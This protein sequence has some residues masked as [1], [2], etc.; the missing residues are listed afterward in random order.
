MRGFFLTFLY[1]FAFVPVYGSVAKVERSQHNDTL[2]D[3]S[4]IIVRIGQKVNVGGRINDTI[5]V[6]FESFGFPIGGFSLKVAALGPL[7]DIVTVLPGQLSDSCKWEYF[8]ARPSKIPMP[9]GPTTMSSVWQV[10][11]LSKMSPDT[12]RVPCLSLDDEHTICY[13]VV[14]NEHVLQMPDTVVPIVFIWQD[15]RDNTIAGASGTQ[16][17]VSKTVV[18]PFSISRDS[19]SELF[20]SLTGTPDQCITYSR[21]NYPRRRIQFVNGGV[22]TIQEGIDESK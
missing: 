5:P 9:A 3:T 13:I 8:N 19:T 10:T 4:H 18:N 6:T 16:I 21:E 1:T 20:P 22:K 17:F 7:L 11:A 12:S 2:T 14:S 15:C